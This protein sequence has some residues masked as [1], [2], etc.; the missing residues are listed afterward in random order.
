ML[1]KLRKMLGSVFNPSSPKE[2]AKEHVAQVKPS[3]K[4][5][6]TVYTS[7]S[8]EEAEKDAGEKLYKMANGVYINQATNDFIKS[9]E[10]PVIEDEMI[11]VF[12]RT[13]IEEGDGDVLAAV[14][15]E[16]DATLIIL[17]KTANPK[18]FRYLVLNFSGENYSRAKQGGIFFNED[19]GNFVV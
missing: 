4:F 16:T 17:S 14:W 6:R 5:G 1:K 12:I 9:E 7:K 10:I 2:Q 11:D 8:L 3:P 13:E 18:E 15:S 19:M